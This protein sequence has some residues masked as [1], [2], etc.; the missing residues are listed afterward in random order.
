M[1]GQGVVICFFVVLGSLEG[2]AIFGQKQK[3]LYFE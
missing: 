1:W 2:F 3:L